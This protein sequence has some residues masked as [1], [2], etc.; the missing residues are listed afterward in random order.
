MLTFVCVFAFGGGL[1][2]DRVFVFTF[3]YVVAVGCVMTFG[4]VLT[5]GCV[6]AFGCV[7]VFDWVRPSA[8]CWPT[9]A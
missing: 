7:L 9:A 3:G 2:L 6:V 8:V 4:C 1:T 5:F